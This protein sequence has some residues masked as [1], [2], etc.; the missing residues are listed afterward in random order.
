MVCPGYA[1]SVYHK[2]LLMLKNSTVNGNLSYDEICNEK[3]VYIA[4]A[5]GGKW[6]WNSISVWVSVMF[7]LYVREFTTLLSQ[8]QFFS[9]DPSK[10]KI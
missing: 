3:Q 2:K 6:R 1:K 4:V 7:I 9:A 10:T 8:C 5:G